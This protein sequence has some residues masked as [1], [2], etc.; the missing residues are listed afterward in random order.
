MSRSPKWLPPPHT[1]R[2]KL[3][4]FI[5]ALMRAKCSAHLILLDLITL[6]IFGSDIILLIIIIIIIIILYLK[7]LMSFHYS[8]QTAA[9]TSFMNGLVSPFSAIPADVVRAPFC[10]CPFQALY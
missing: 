5:T 2:P 10:H 4:A 9:A 8:L 3:Y 1:F 7:R 6:I